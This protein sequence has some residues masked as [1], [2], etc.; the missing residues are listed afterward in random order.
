MWGGDEEVMRGVSKGAV[1]T[2]PAAHEG[3]KAEGKEPPPPAPPTAGQELPE[4]KG[5]EG[6]GRGN[7]GAKSAGSAPLTSFT[8]SSF[9]TQTWGASEHDPRTETSTS[10]SGEETSS[11]TV[12]ESP[13]IATT[14]LP[15]SNGSSIPVSIERVEGATDTRRSIR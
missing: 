6:G 1:T 9:K 5:R 11:K 4:P 12:G 13:E 3:L 15:I 8:P 10:G 2:T 14:S 7:A